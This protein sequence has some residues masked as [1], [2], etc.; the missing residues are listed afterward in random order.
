[1][2]R[3]H[4]PAPAPA[5]RLSHFQTQ[6]AHHRTLKVK[7]VRF[8]FKF[9]RFHYVIQQDGLSVSP[10]RPGQQSSNNPTATTP[11]GLMAA[12]INEE[13]ANQ[14]GNQIL[15]FYLGGTLSYLTTI[16]LRVLCF[17][18]RLF[19]EIH[20]SCLIISIMNDNFNHE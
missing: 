2:V 5:G 8:S 19:P 1:M 11:K 6:M 13:N 7:K 12:Q 16:V 3:R 10:R 14:V 17:H 9:I 18:H 4:R 20:L 15:S